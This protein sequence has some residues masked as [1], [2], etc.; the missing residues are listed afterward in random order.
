MSISTSVRSRSVA[1]PC[2]V[3][4]HLPHKPRKPLEERPQGQHH[5]LFRVLEQIVDG[6]P[7]QAAI[8]SHRRAIIP[9]RPASPFSR[10]P[11]ASI[12]SGP[13]GR[14]VR[15]PGSKRA[16]AATSRRGVRPAP[17]ASWRASSRSSLN[18][19]GPPSHDDFG[20]RA[21]PPPATGPSRVSRSKSGPNP[22][23]AGL[24]KTTG[25]EGRDSAGT[26][27]A[28]AVSGVFGRRP[29]LR[30][31]MAAKGAAGR[32][33]G[34]DPARKRLNFAARIA[35]QML[36][37]LR[38]AASRSC[39]GARAVSQAA[40]L[41]KRCQH[42]ELFR[43]RRERAFF[44]GRKTRPQAPGIPSRLAASPPR[45]RLLSG[46]ALRGKTVSTSACRL[47]SGGRPLRVPQPRRDPCTCSPA[48]SVTHRSVVERTLRS[49]SGI[50]LL[51]GLL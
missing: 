10:T 43:L 37:R 36:H 1:L 29:G 48:S 6:I 31:R 45:A 51:L 21:F 20:T 44:P 38:M 17:V 35:L 33:R 5:E 11:C 34:N 22:P 39:P 7:H 26:R 32:R 9:I 49:S 13:R 4:R 3:P 40:G 28:A 30:L 46:C 27:T 19:V 8:T 18:S 41:M 2:L 12:M 14:R 24:Q 25:R 47:S 50:A 42:R 16:T 23:Q 15:R